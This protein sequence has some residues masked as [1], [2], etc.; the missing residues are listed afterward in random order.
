MKKDWMQRVVV[1]MPWTTEVC[2]ALASVM[3]SIQAAW[4]SWALRP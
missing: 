1:V 3:P 4:A 2:P